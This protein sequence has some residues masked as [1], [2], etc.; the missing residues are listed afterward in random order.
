MATPDF[1]RRRTDPET[2]GHL[3]E[4]EQASGPQ[5]AEAVLETAAEADLAYPEAV[6]GLV[7]IRAQSALVQDRGDLGVGVAVKQVVNRLH[8]LGRSLAQQVGWKW[9]R[10]VVRSAPDSFRL[11]VSEAK[12]GY[13]FD[14]IVSRKK[15]HL[16]GEYVG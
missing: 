9:S 2:L 13:D 1:H 12:R 11:P 8:G 3:V 6:E 15:H 5:V 4:G 7:G 10:S 14:L 16:H